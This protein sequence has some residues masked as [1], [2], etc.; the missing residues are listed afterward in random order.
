MFVCPY[1][2]EEEDVVRFSHFANCNG[3]VLLGFF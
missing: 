3:P 2:E 1:K